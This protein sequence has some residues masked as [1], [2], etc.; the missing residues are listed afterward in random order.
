MM[1]PEVVPLNIRL[2]EM[3]GEHDRLLNA[4]RMS[5]PAYAL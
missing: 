2:L 4:R 1:P 3:L 5:G